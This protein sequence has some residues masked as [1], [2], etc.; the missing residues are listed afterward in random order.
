MKTQGYPERI[1]GHPNIYGKSYEKRQ[2]SDHT[3]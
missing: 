3:D 2:D 1:K